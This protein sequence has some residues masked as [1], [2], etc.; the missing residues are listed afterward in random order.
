MSFGISVLTGNDVVSIFQSPGEKVSQLC[1]K[2]TDGDIDNVIT[3]LDKEEFHVDIRQ[4]DKSEGKSKDCW[5]GT[6]DGGGWGG[7]NGE[8]YYS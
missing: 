1:N 5:A 6:W 7:E 4:K 2:H 3:L 8:E